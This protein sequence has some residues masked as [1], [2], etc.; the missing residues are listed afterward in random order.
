MENDAWNL[1]SQVMSPQQLAEL[2]DLILDWI[3]A[4]PD[5]VAVDYIRFSDFGDI[6]K[7]PNLKEIQKPGG[8]LAPVREAKQAVDEIRMTSERAM[9]L[10]TKMQ[11]IV[12]FQAELVYQ[13]LVMQPEVVKALEDVTKFR[14]TTEHFA[15]LLEK[16][17]ADVAAERAAVMKEFDVRESKIRGIIGEVQAT[18]DRVDGTFANL[19]KTTADAERLLAGTQKTGLIFQ[20]LVQSVDKLAARFESKGTE[21]PA[22]PF[23]IKDYTEALER[24]QNTVQNLNELVITVDQTSSLWITNITKE[25]NDAADKRVDHIFWR[26]AELFAIIAVMV[27]ILVFL[28]NLFRRRLVP[29]SSMKPE[30]IMKI[31]E[32]L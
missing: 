18:L 31:D 6:G 5:Q 19:Q 29:E 20:N 24:L 4:N 8:L 30:S 3:A 7:K 15:V 9:F 25:F 2:K 21:E 16:L 27:L 12:G 32:N 11:L 23:D 26:L 28:N 1:A 22:R 13:Q 17:P 10:A 14:E